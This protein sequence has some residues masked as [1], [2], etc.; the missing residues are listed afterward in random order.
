MGR[1]LF[2]DCRG[3]PLR[4]QHAF[5]IK[6]GLV[7]VRDKYIVST[8]ENGA[9]QYQPH[10]QEIGYCYRDRHNIESGNQLERCRVVGSHAESN[11][12]A[13]AARNGFSTNGA[14]MYVIGHDYISTSAVALL[15]TLEFAG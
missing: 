12:I 8:G 15:P 1:I 2:E 4:D 5:A 10:C 7:L 6:W 14:R 9:P 3:R 13:L 11:A